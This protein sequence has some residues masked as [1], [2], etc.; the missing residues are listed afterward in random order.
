[1]AELELSARE[2]LSE[3]LGQIHDRAA[4]LALW[5]MHFEAHAA[6]ASEFVMGLERLLALPVRPEGFTIE[7]A[8]LEQETRGIHERLG[9]LLMGTD[10][11]QAV[12]IISHAGTVHG[13]AEH[14]RLHGTHGLTAINL[15]R[16]A[17][18]YALKEAKRAQSELTTAQQAADDAGSAQGPLVRE[19]G[20]Y[21][22]L[23]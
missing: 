13:H 11:E 1:V 12:A 10:N 22:A 21:I 18:G 20:E 15:M 19:L 3:E 16:A 17:L 4:D 9:Q 6:P 14:M 8:T 23:L 7:P 2:A 5:D